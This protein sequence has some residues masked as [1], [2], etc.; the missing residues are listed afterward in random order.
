M[1][2]TDSRSVGEATRLSARPLI[3][4][5]LPLALA[6]SLF[7]PLFA[8]PDVALNLSVALYTATAI[9]WIWHKRSQTAGRWATLIAHAAL[10]GLAVVLFDRPQ[11]AFLSCLVTGY[12]SAMLNTRTS[13]AAAMGQTMM[14]AGLALARQMLW[15]DVA[16]AASLNGGV[17][18]LLAAI[19]RPIYTLT[20]WA[21]QRYDQA[22]TLLE[23]ARDR[24]AELKGVVD[25]LAHANRELSLAH[26]RLAVLRL[27]AEDAR[28]IKASFVANVSHEFRAPLNIIVGMAEILLDAEE[29]YGH[30]LPTAV[31]EDIE[32]LHRNC[33]HLTDL[34]NDVLDLSQIEVDRLALRREWVSMSAIVE[35]AVRIVVPL[36]EK[37]GLT[38]EARAPDGL[39]PVYCDPRRIRQVV[40]NLVSNAARFTESG[41]IDIDTWVE[42]KEVFVSVRDTGP[43]I[44]PVDSERIFEPFQQ[45]ATAGA[46][47]GKGSGLGLAVSREFIR[48]HEGA[49]WLHST[50]GQGSTF[51]FRL[52]ITPSPE[53]VAAATRWVSEDW[54]RRTSSSL[55]DSP[56]LADRAVLWDSSG[57]LLGAL[58]R[59]ADDLELVAA[60]DAGS[61]ER[62]CQA[63]AARTVIVSSQEM[64]ELVDHVDVLRARIRGVPL[65]GFLL[66]RGEH[67]EPST[68]PLAYITKPVSGHDL[69]KTLAALAANPR[70]VL[71]VD[72]EPDARR[73]LTTRLKSSYEGIEIREAGSAREALDTAA[74]WRPDA[75]LL[76][77]VMPEMDGWAMLDQANSH[78]DLRAVPIVLISGRDR[79]QEP[80]GASLFVAT[81]QDG[82][83]FGKLV[84]CYRAVSEILL[85]RSVEP[86]IAPRESS[87]GPPA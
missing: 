36:A 37:K 74:V 24:Q 67:A 10:I 4:L 46:V 61:V 30:D 87:G 31:R 22:R 33:E 82:I 1:E 32:V 57:Q 70:R 16:F 19:V 18:L 12:A 34:V 75:I 2:K 55:L 58:S 13:A 25:A 45:S 54:P 40:L 27:V 48:M 8:V 7:S 52:P 6:L 86:R 23:E 85:P 39:E 59:Y 76:D 77:L 26:D 43:G 29:V 9:L 60:A 17:V 5:L 15:I 73:V 78:P 35:S 84:D 49:L 69:R 71:I 28:K 79:Y 44:S 11:I 41:G 56:R 42:G 72:D 81:A 38:I 53:P 21:Q 14:F 68:R 80:L 51:T 20:Y 50:P 62:E 66:S 64:A 83:S 65:F 3:L 63:H 47:L